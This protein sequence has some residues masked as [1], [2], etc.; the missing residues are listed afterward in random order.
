MVR[1]VSRASNT[2][3]LSLLRLSEKLEDQG[4]NMINGEVFTMSSEYRKDA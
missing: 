4:F 2:I 3:L 1:C